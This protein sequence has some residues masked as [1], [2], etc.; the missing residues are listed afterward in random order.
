MST[1]AESVGARYVVTLLASVSRAALS[2]VA[3]LILARTLGAHEYGD[4]AF[5]LGS[6]VAVSQLLDMR[7]SSAFYTILARR[8][9]RPLFFAGYGF[10]LALQF[11]VPAVFVL[12]VSQTFLGAVWQGQDRALI[13]LC[14]A[15]SFAS[16]QLW[17]AVS[18]LGEAVRRTRTVQLASLVQ[19]A[20]HVI[21]VAVLAWTGWLTIRAFFWLTTVEYGLLVAIVAPRLIASN[22][23]PGAQ[24]E[25]LRELL[26][27]CA[28][29][30]RPLVIYG[31]VAFL[32]TF[33]DRWLLQY[34]G[35]ASEQGFFAVSQQFAA[36]TLLVT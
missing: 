30:C 35:G 1:H 26:R 11:A 33:A 6:F 13:L 14:W 2:F 22:V 24:H 20:A 16:N 29:Y 15:S 5:L 8:S 32:Y 36:V 3:G 18:Q 17:G 27:A 21:T 25:P 12:V 23:E 10:W 7:S 9:R 28:T 34:F 4:Q 19:S 31:W